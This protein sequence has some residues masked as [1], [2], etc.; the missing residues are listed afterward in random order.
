M[1]NPTFSESEHELLGKNLFIAREQLLPLV[2]HTLAT[3]RPY[4]EKRKAIVCRNNL[5]Q[6]LDDL[7]AFLQDKVAARDFTVSQACDW[8][9]LG[10]TTRAPGILVCADPDLASA[11]IKSY[12]GKIYQDG[13]KKPAFNLIDFLA[14]ADFLDTALTSKVELQ[15]NSL[16]EQITNQ[17]KRRKIQ[18]LLRLVI[19]ARLEFSKAL[20]TVVFKAMV[21][22]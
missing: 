21:E 3:I 10:H 14:I 22:G 19:G 15:I 8:Y 7:R 18:E 6:R 2:G 9:A 13:K 11:F 1:A 20:R 4:K 5:A 17:G 12:N 16:T